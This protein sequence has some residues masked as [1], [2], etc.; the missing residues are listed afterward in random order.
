MVEAEVP[1]EDPHHPV[2]GILLLGGAARWGGHDAREL[3][4][5]G[6]ERHYPEKAGP[7]RRNGR[8]TCSDSLDENVTVE[9]NVSHRLEEAA[10]LAEKGRHRGAGDVGAPLHLAHND[11]DHALLALVEDSLLVVL[12]V[13]LAGDFYGH[14]VLVWGCGG[15]KQ[16][17]K[18]PFEAVRRIFPI[19]EGQQK[20]L[21]AHP[22]L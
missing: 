9:Q 10:R 8:A 22:S 20:P 2:N 15:V 21:S 17:R 13:G 18:M 6:A 16:R 14:F 11:G 7:L 1:L 12:I 19:L 3:I 4:V 5:G